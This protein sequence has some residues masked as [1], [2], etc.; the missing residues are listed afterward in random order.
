MKKTLIILWLVLL[1]SAVSALFWYNDWVYQL[2]TPVPKDYKQVKPGTTI[3][4][5][6]PLQAYH[7][8]PL[9]L[10]F[11]NPE[12][13][14]SRFNMAHFKS[15]VK[16]YGKQVHFV[17]VVVSSKKF[18]A[19]AVKDKYDLDLPIL[20][21]QTALAKSCGVYSTPQAVL[22]DDRHRLVYRGNYNSSRY[23][24][25]EKTSYAKIA[26]TDFLQEQAHFSTVT[27]PLALKA[28]GCSLPG[29][30]N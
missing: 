13:P 30:V 26:L 5:T 9:F 4:L 15:L 25:D 14:C 2:P 24:A 10:H 3:A 20:F 23:C 18:T 1:F 6:N 7:A 19:E 11:F 17:I 8:R 29:C 22:L 21:D 16:Q 12:C 28:Y 27:N